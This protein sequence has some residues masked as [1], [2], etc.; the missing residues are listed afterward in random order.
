MTTITIPRETFDQMREA[1]QDAATSL[2]TI[3]RLAG[4]THYVGDDG[5]R[6]ETYMGHHDEVRGYA[7]SRAPVAREALA[8]A[9][10]VEP[11]ASELVGPSG[12]ALSDFKADQWWL[13]ELDAAVA[14]GTPDQKRAVAVVRNMLATAAKAIVADKSAHGDNNG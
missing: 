13:P 12:D 5:E 6:I 4:R 10:A 1:L 8:A 2:E 7:T 3:S 9:K 14:N 11:Q